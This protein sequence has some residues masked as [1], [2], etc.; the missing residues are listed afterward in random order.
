MTYTLYKI[1]YLNKA[2]IGLTKDFKRRKSEHFLN[3][4]KK[5]N[6]PLYNALN[7]YPMNWDIIDYASSFEE[8]CI[9]EKQY[10]KQLNTK[11]PYGYNL[12]DGGEGVWGILDNGMNLP[13]LRSDGIEFRSVSHAARE[14]KVNGNS[15]RAVLLGNSLQCKG[16]SFIDLEGRYTEI[17]KARREKVK[18]HKDLIKLK[19]I[20]FK[21][22]LEKKANNFTK[23]SSSQ[24]HGVRKGFKCWESCIYIGKKMKVLNRYKTELEAVLDRE[25]AVQNQSNKRQNFINGFKVKYENKVYTNYKEVL[26]LITK[27]REQ[28]Y[29]INYKQFKSLFKLKAI[30][31]GIKTH[32]NVRNWKN[33]IKGSMKGLVQKEI[34]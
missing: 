27:L 1:S 34:K 24:F 10:I 3:A 13:I 11:I 5:I 21:M 20:L 23:R 12:T 8:A 22:K 32:R 9:K 7:K 29:E 31:I 25:I 2:Y 19:G 28:G 16:Y 15:I 4:K 33:Y 14:M 6:T 17:Q 30:F 18:K 26:E